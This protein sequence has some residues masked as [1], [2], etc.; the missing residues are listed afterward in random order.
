MDRDYSKLSYIQKLDLLNTELKKI[1]HEINISKLIYEYQ[2]NDS[3]EHLFR[4]NISMLEDKYNGI[5][6]AIENLKKFK[7]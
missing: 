7:C 3:Y 6:F 2:D 4:D 5:L 1:R